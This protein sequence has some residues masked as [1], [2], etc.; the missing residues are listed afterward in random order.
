M[1]LGVLFL[2]TAIA[3]VERSGKNNGAQAS[4]TSSAQAVHINGPVRMEER[5][6]YCKLVISIC[7]C[8]HLN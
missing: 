8:S 2:V 6:F 7:P 3:N 4:I 1:L 5:M